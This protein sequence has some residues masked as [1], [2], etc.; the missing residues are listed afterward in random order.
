MKLDIPITKETRLSFSREELGIIDNGI[1]VGLI[2][3]RD[4]LRRE[5]DATNQLLRGEHKGLDLI[6]AAMMKA[7]KERDD[8]QLRIAKLVEGCA[9]RIDALHSDLSLA[10]E[11]ARRQSDLL[12]RCRTA[13]FSVRATLFDPQIEKVLEAISEEIREPR[14]H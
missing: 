13:L 1:H 12:D 10:N 4:K 6:T 3:E 9:A 11:K 8:L 2:E 5:L 14:T 7:E